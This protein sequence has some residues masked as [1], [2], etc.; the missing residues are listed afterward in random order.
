MSVIKD[1]MVPLVCP[2]FEHDK[3]CVGCASESPRAFCAVSDKTK[4][5]SL[6]LCVKLILLS[7]QGAGLL[8]RLSAR[9]RSPRPGHRLAVSRARSTSLRRSHPDVKPTMA[10]LRPV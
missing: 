10:L 8:P 4:E 3:D 2:L 1:K 7:C 5:A 9:R 6:L